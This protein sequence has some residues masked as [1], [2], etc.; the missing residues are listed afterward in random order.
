MIG[1]V[2]GHFKAPG[3]TTAT[4]E[5]VDKFRS[6]TLSY[7]LRV[8]PAQAGIHNRDVCLFNTAVNRFP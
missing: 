5:T 3:P 4:R 6:H 1:A 7:S 8:I 2:F